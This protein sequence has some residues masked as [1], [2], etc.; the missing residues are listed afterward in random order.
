MLAT[1]GSVTASLYTKRGLF[2]LERGSHSRYKGTQVMLGIR[3]P[4]VEERRSERLATVAVTLFVNTGVFVLE[5]GVFA[6]RDG[7]KAPGA[8]TPL[9]YRQRRTCLH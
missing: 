1:T 8:V 3:R 2:M 5:K 9:S 7:K 4:Q 6:L